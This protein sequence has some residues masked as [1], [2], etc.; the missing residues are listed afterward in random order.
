METKAKIGIMGAAGFTGGELIRLLLNHP[1]ITLVSLQS[2]SQAGKKISA[3]HPDLR[4]KFRKQI[5]LPIQV[6]LLLLSNWHFCLW[7]MLKN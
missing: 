3:V 4:K 7:R 5:T 2:R 1:N 6:A